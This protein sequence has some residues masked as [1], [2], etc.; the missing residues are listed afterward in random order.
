MERH[1]GPALRRCSLPN[2][3]NQNE[4]FARSK[5]RLSYRS[6]FD[7]DSPRNGRHRGQDCAGGQSRRTLSGTL[8][9]DSVGFVA[10][11]RDRIRD[12]VDGSVRFRCVEEEL[13]EPAS[14]ATVS[15]LPG[16]AS[17]SC[18][19]EKDSSILELPEER[20]VIASLPTTPQ[21]KSRYSLDRE[22]VK[23]S[24]G[25]RFRLSTKDRNVQEKRNNDASTFGEVSTSTN[26][27]VLSGKQRNVATTAISGVKSSPDVTETVSPRRTI[28]LG[29]G[30]SLSIV[31]AIRRSQASNRKNHAIKPT[32]NVVKQD[33]NHSKSH[34]AMDSLA[35][36]RTTASTAVED[37]PSIKN[38]LD[39]KLWLP[40]SI[41]VHTSVITIGRGGSSVLTTRATP[42]TYQTI[43]P[44]CRTVSGPFQVSVMQGQTGLGIELVVSPAGTIITRIV[45]TGPVGR[46]GNV[47]YELFRSVL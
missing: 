4:L 7:C 35:Y 1:E 2:E 28:Y 3:L 45:D 44:Q 43:L 12:D 23:R 32:F 31:L 25:V 34:N 27:Q 40:S 19:N 8:A 18:G 33:G 39:R 47:R 46:N 11:R 10:T 15:D 29:L 9:A 21:D 42:S 17:D 26:R 24:K 5:L 20:R 16:R 22:T 41:V 38:G 13:S 30:T 37:N 6:G 36:L 14:F